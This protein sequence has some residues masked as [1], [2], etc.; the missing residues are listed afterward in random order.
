MEQEDKVIVSHQEE[1]EIINLGTKE[2]KKEIKIGA[3]MP[4]VEKKELS[5]PPS[6]N[7]LVAK[8]FE[9]ILFCEKRTIQHLSLKVLNGSKLRFLFSHVS[10]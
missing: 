8:K 7:T 2:N 5:T 10:Y 6:T 4:K 3:L 1:T 9:E